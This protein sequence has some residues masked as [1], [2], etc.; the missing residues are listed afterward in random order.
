MSGRIFGNG[1]LRLALG[2]VLAAAVATFA[3]LPAIMLVAVLGGEALAAWPSE[4]MGELMEA[5]TGTFALLPFAV[6][7]TAL[8]GLPMHLALAAMRR[9]GVGAYML[10]GAI[11]GALVLG[12][13]L[14][15]VPETLTWRPFL[16][17]AP[18]GALAGMAFRM[19]WSPA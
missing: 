8:G 14:N 12:G 7:F 2:V 17:G 19:V 18:L 16:Q 13:L 10:A 15:L 1:L 3:G 4:G 5:W 6:M 9:Q 11:G